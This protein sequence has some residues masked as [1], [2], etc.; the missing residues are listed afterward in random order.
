VLAHLLG[1]GTR[2]VVVTLAAD[3]IGSSSNAAYYD[4]LGFYVPETLEGGR[5]K[6]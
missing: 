3:K 6:A 2:R 1:R 5:G 4:N